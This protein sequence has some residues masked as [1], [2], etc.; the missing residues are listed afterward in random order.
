MASIVARCTH[1]LVVVVSLPLVG[2]PCTWLANLVERRTNTRPQKKV[3]KR[4]RAHM[5]F[6]V[7]G[8]LPLRV[9]DADDA[10][11]A[12]DAGDVVP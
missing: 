10:G 12:G 5:K 7:R 2:L 4:P 8:L 3:I 11:D 9:I 1:A 6:P